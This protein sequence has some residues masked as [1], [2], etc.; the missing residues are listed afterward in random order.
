MNHKRLWIAAAII[1]LVIVGGFVLSV[2]HTRDIGH[3]AAAQTA[4]ASVPAVTLHDVYTKGVHTITLRTKANADHGLLFR[5]LG[6][7][8]HDLVYTIVL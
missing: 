6:G 3:P 8:L 5:R 4:A 1:A 7:V 2:P